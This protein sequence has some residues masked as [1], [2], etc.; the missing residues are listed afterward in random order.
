MQPSLCFSDAAAATVLSY[1]NLPRPASLIRRMQTTAPDG[2]PR[3]SSWRLGGSTAESIGRFVS[4]EFFPYF[5]ASYRSTCF[6]ITRRLPRQKS[7]LVMSMPNR[8]AKGDG[9]ILPGVAQQLRV[10]RHKRLPSLFDRPHT[11]RGRTGGRTRRGSCRSS[12]RGCSSAASRA[13][14]RDGRSLRRR[15]RHRF[16]AGRRSSAYRTRRG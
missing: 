15:R 1:L 8:L 14:C 4:R 5:S 11:V 9:P 16:A 2:F 13:T 6:S 12:S 7:G 10:A 3:D